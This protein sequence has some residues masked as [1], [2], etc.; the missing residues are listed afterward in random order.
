MTASSASG[1]VGVVD[2][3]VVQ[4]RQGVP[5]DVDQRQGAGEPANCQKRRF[6]FVL[7]VALGVGQPGLG[8]GVFAGDGL[9]QVAGAGVDGQEGLVAVVGRDEPVALD[10][11]SRPGSTGRA[12]RRASPCASWRPWRSP[13][14]PRRACRAGR[15]ARRR[16]SPPRRPC[17]VGLLGGL[18]PSEPATSVE[19]GAL[20]LVDL[21]VRLGESQRAIRPRSS[22]PVVLLAGGGQ[23]P[24]RL[25]TTASGRSGRRRPPGSRRRPAGAQPGPPGS[26]PGRV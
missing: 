14:R 8:D 20:A 4:G 24:S 9:L 13:S 7:A 2:A 21:V 18:Q 3:D 16:R 25:G 22:R 1:P 17:R 15:A 11:G 23:W 26:E 5:V 10:T 6:D 19:V 12:R